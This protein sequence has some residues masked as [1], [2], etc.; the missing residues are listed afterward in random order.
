MARSEMLNSFMKNNFIEWKNVSPLLDPIGSAFPKHQVS[1][2]DQHALVC[3][4]GQVRTVM[5]HSLFLVF[6]SCVLH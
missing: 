3:F 6:R 2:K 1:A 4:A 5:C